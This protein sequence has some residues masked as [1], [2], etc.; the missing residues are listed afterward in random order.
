MPIRAEVATLALRLQSERLAPALRAFADEVADPTCDLVVAAL[1]LAAEHQ[2]NRLGE[3]LGSLAQ[4][5][6]D[7]ATMRLRVEAG[8]ARVR[9]SVKV[10]V[11]VTAGLVLALAVL[12][13]GYLAPY[14]TRRRPARARPGRR[15]LRVGVLLAGPHDPTGQRRAVPR[16]SSATT[17]DSRQNVG[18]TT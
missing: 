10:I 3:L 11:G 9:T 18:I 16:V 6:R 7:Q 8:R 12:N 1:I 17:R 4:A 5:A 14:D 13:R 2:A 15:S